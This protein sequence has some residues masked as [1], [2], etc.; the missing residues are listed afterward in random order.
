MPFL[1]ALLAPL[2][3]A[4]LAAPGAPGAD[5][6]TA[7]FAPCTAQA[8]VTCVD[9]GDTFWY[10]GAK[11]RVA[12]IDTPEVSRP[13]CPR[14]AELGRAATARLTALL[15]AG[16]FTL[17]PWRPDRDRYGRLLRTVTRQG[18]SLGMALVSEGLARP[19]LKTGPG[20]GAGWC[21]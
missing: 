19:W 18:E 8:R 16:P 15:N 11:I 1:A 9:D 2:A 21:G 20:P 13:A 6:E 17:A 5:L 3:A 10:C 4:A 14:E 12:D 7:R